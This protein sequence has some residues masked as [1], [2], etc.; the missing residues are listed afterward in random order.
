[1]VV[2]RN[3]QEIASL[4]NT[5]AE[6]EGYRKNQQ[7][8]L[9]VIKNQRDILAQQIVKKKK[10]ILLLSEKNK[11]AKSVRK[12][13]HFDY[14]SVQDE[15][16]KLKRA[17]VDV[18]DQIRAAEGEV[19]V[20][21]ELKQEKLKL[22]SELNKLEIKARA[23]SDDTMVKVNIHNYNNLMKTQP[24]VY[25]KIK[26]VQNLAKKLIAKSDE[27]NMKDKLIQEKEKL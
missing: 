13:R 14:L 1:M 21:P 17:I 6:A 25:E 24:E 19:S 26:K 9:E 27:V 8:E 22:E 18:N 7:Q 23:L 16:A 15:I 2:K 10:E 5:L 20:I 3:N 11:I 12:K 4:K